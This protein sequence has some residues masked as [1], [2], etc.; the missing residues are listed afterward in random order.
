MGKLLVH[1]ELRWHR[2]VFLGIISQKRKII[3]ES[4]L[5]LL[6]LAFLDFPHWQI[7]LFDPDCMILQTVMLQSVA[8]MHT[9]KTVSTVC[10]IKVLYFKFF[11]GMEWCTENKFKTTS[12][13]VNGTLLYVWDII[14][15]ESNGR[16]CYGK[17]DSF[18][19]QVSTVYNMLS[20]LQQIW[21]YSACNN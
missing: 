14:K 3:V 21:H 2:E 9:N 7:K 5:C 10:C 18:F 12:M 6:N 17:V 11:Q 19:T 1:K 20:F 4:G 13:S 16:M 8:T 15:Y